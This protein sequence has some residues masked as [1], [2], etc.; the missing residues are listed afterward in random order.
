MTE[1]FKFRHAKVSENL[2]NVRLKSR[3]ETR[4]RLPFT[5][6]TPAKQ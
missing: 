5:K 1:K 2:I 6:S 4:H 3:D